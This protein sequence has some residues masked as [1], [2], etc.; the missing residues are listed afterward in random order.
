MTLN[1]HCN[2]AVYG[3]GIFLIILGVV[4]GLTWSSAFNYILKE[5]LKL[6]P[7]SKSYNL[8]KETP[9]PLYLDIYLFNWTNSLEFLKDSNVKPKFEEV[10][11]FVFREVHKRV[12]VIWSN[13]TVT[14]N[15]TR[16][17]FFVTEDSMDLKSNITNLNVVLTVSILYIFLVYV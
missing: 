12:N 2:F 13:N 10:G 3:L 15:Q 5:N 16:T 6:S 1:K 8:W 4:I 11:P 9:I 14:Y 7:S 17:W